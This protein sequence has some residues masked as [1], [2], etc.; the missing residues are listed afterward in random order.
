MLYR[1]APSLPNTKN[2]LTLSS[3]VNF[4]TV[5][6]EIWN[7]QKTDLVLDFWDTLHTDIPSHPLTSLST[8]AYD[9]AVSS[10]NYDATQASKF[11]T[12]H[13]SSIE[14]WPK[15]WIKFYLEKSIIVI[16]TPRRAIFWPIYMYWSQFPLVSQVRYLKLILG[17]WRSWNP[18]TQLKR[19][20][21]K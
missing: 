18:H 11:L 4:S 20:D 2:N 19:A 15:W 21:T 14:R 9:K 13:L 7:A 1:V 12:E 17:P 10:T 16:F 6:N 3:I 5:S 8:C